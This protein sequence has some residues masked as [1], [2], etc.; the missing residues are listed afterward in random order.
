MARTNDPQ[1]PRPRHLHLLPPA[2]RFAPLPVVIP[3]LRPNERI[4]PA[5]DVLLT[6]LARRALAGDHE[7]LELLWRGLAPRLEPALRRCGRMTWQADWVRRDGRPWELDDLRQEAWLVFGELTHGWNGEEPFVPYVTAYFPWRLRK[8]MRRLGP[9]RRAAPIHLVVEPV[10][11]C[12]DLLDAE[13]AELLTAIAAE[14]SAAD[15]RV[16]RMRLGEGAGFADI[17]CRLGV[18]ERTVF[19]RWARIRRVAQAFLGD[20]DNRAN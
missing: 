18:S 8:A 6:S 15:A 14:L 2:P 19:R 12:L 17:A 16:L 4:T 3:L 20:P 10:A 1:K 11:D 5:Q 9:T 13:T 7:A